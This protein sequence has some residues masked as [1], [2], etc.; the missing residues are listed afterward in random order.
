M[1]DSIRGRNTLVSHRTPDFAETSADVSEFPPPPKRTPGMLLAIGILA[2]LLVLLY[3]FQNRHKPLA[4]QTLVVLA[5]RTASQLEHRYQLKLAGRFPDD[6]QPKTIC[7][8]IPGVHPRLTIARLNRYN[9]SR[10][11]APISGTV[12]LVGQQQFPANE[13]AC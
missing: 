3:Q 7:P 5:N 12:E 11:V 13:K 8:L 6:L 9:Y 1:S 2:I 4:F 10:Y